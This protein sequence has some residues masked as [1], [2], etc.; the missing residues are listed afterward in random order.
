MNKRWK[1]GF[2]GRPLGD[3]HIRVGSERQSGPFLRGGKSV[4]VPPRALSCNQ[5]KLA[6]ADR[7]QKQLVKR[8]LGDSH[9]P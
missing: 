9:R 5:Q 4:D 8:M 6:L 7:A 3:P 1:R 2:Q